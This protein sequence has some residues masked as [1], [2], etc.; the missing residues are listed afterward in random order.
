[1]NNSDFYKLKYLKYK[2]KYISLKNN[3][4][5]GGKVGLCAFFCNSKKLFDN[6]EFGGSKE[7]IKLKKK[8]A[9]EEINPKLETLRKIF[10]DELVGVEVGNNMDEDS[11]NFLSKE[12]T[13]KSNSND[14]FRTDLSKIENI[15]RI[16]IKINKCF[17]T[18]EEETKIDLCL[19][20]DVKPLTK[21]T[22]KEIIFFR[23]Q[24][25]T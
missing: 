18:M 4:Q 5:E 8:D 1:M 22:I 21:N 25:I 13:C 11:F 20:I 17:K 24:Q 3:N 9:K 19:I 12:K 16:L 15:K 10:T 7:D 2:N 14:K 23:P 6:Y